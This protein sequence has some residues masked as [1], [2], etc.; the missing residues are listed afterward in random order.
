M[1]IIIMVVCLFVAVST[2][3]SRAS[4]NE[5]M[6]EDQLCERIEEAYKNI[7]SVQK[8][9]ERARDQ[10]VERLSYLVLV[11]GAY[12]NGS[13]RLDAIFSR[14]QKETPTI[15]VPRYVMTPSELEILIAEMAKD[16]TKGY[17]FSAY[18][19]KLRYMSE[20]INQAK[21]AITKRS[22]FQ[23]D[24]SVTVIYAQ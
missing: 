18:L 21:V 12:S 1:R 15:V 8:G 5:L 14:I 2:T 17:A 7:K 6:N 20:F 19:R 10:Y 22:G 4:G 16:D 9:Y 11:A 13:K 23:F 3:N 24:P